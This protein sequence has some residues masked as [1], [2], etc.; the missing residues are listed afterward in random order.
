MPAE[1]PL[2][3]RIKRGDR[4]SGPPPPPWKITKIYGFFSNTGPDPLENYKT[5]KQVFIVGP[6]SARQRTPFQWCFACGLIMAHFKWYKSPLPSSTKTKKKKKRCQTWTPSDKTFWIP[7]WSYLV[8][9]PGD[10]LSCE[11][12]VGGWAKNPFLGSPFGI[13]RLAEWWQ[14]VI[15]KGRIFLSHPYTNNGLFFLLTIGFL[16]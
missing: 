8:A 15:P 9:N 6:S 2:H 11:W 4:G 10:R 7:A 12:V 1:R 14:T 13:T 16:F 5:T 3:A